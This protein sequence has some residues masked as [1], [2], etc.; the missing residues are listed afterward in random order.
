MPMAT[1]NQRSSS[2]LS[3]FDL[4]RSMPRDR[5]F[6]DTGQ[7]NDV[8][9]NRAVCQSSYEWGRRLLEKD[10]LRFHQFTS[11]H[12]PTYNCVSVHRIYIALEPSL[13]GK[14][15]TTFKAVVLSLVTKGVSRSCRTLSVSGC[16][17]TIYSQAS[18]RSPEPGRPLAALRPQPHDRSGPAY[19]YRS[20]HAPPP[21]LGHAP[22]RRA[23]A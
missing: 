7:R 8:L 22:R 14:E 3:R 4:G 2:R 23:K 13:D 9:R 5:K 16:A 18:L 20:P 15:P 1:S 10:R 12:A 6:E 11:T 17:R 21:Q 19:S